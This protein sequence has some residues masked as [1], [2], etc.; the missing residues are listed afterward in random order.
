MKIEMVI[1]NRQA[2]SKL[3]TYITRTLDVE[4]DLEQTEEGY[5]LLAF[6]DTDEEEKKINIKAIEI[7]EGK[8]IPSPKKNPAPSPVQ[9]LFV[10]LMKASG[11]VLFGFGKAVCRTTKETA[12]YAVESAKKNKQL[13]YE[14]LADDEN[15]QIVQS[16]LDD[17]LGK[18]DLAVN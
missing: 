3:Y 18:E 16:Y 2:A 4:A 15:V 1:K 10:P 11:S 5:V 12:C 8:D 9:S 6:P 14:E 17:Y 13:Y 7:S